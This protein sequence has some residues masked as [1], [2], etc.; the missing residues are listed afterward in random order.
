MLPGWSGFAMRPANVGTSVNGI[1]VRT[2]P[3]TRGVNSFA[4]L[5]RRPVRAITIPAAPQRTR[6][7]ENAAGAKSVAA[8]AAV[9]RIADGP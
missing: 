2:V 6:A 3:I 5:A 1:K 4:T 8:T 9:S 7:V